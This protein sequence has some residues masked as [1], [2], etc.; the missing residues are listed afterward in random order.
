[1]NDFAVDEKLLKEVRDL[2]SPL[3]REEF[4]EKLKRGPTAVTSLKISENAIF[5]KEKSDLEHKYKLIEKNFNKVN[6]K[7][8]D[9]IDDL[10][11]IRISY[12][13]IKKDLNVL[14]L[15]NERI[16]IEKINN[17]KLLEE[18]KNYTRKL[19]S[20]LVQGAKNQYLIEINNKLR[21]E[22]EDLK[23]YFI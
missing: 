13:N 6:K 22:I 10:K 21:I 9:L 17:E 11:N 14:A 7:N 1:M 20:R 12:D 19:E 8:V 3:T 5:K 18:N 23:V 2:I 15:A 4:P 16:Q